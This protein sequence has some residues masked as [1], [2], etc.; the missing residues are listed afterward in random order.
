M[1]IADFKCESYLEKVD[2]IGIA[3]SRLLPTDNDDEYI[4]HNFDVFR[5]DASSRGHT[6]PYHGTV[7]YSQ[8]Q[9]QFCCKFWGS[10]QGI[11]TTV[12]E[13]R[14][15]QHS[16][17]VIFIYCPPK[18]A[19]FQNFKVFIREV[20]Q[21]ICP[22]QTV[23]LGDFNMDANAQCSLVDMMLQNKFKQLVKGYTTDYRTTI[24]HIYSNIENGS[25]TTGTLECYYS[26]HKPI[27]VCIPLQ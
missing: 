4:I 13:I 21:F 25:I 10:L 14:K 8:S 7:V 15:G 2:L 1:H 20:Q 3:E 16:F 24:D 22:G 27:L 26:D 18:V 17:V 5:N 6:R 12:V 19:S 11:E 9:L 23:I